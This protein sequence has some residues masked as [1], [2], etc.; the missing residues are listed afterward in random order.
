M[1]LF[2]FFWKI[3]IDKSQNTSF[4][5][6]FKDFE[7]IIAPLKTLRL[8]FNEIEKVKTTIL[9]VNTNYYY[10]CVT[11]IYRLHSQLARIVSYTLLL[12]HHKPEEVGSHRL[13]KPRPFLNLPLCACCHVSY[14]GEK[15]VEIPVSSF[16]FGEK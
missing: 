6:Y 9:W 2:S 13:V 7:E 14:V 8:L 10:F 16:E 12:T 15:F 4:Y 11:L 5:F 3:K 1:F